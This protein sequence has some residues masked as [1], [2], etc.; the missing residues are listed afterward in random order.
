MFHLICENAIEQLML[1]LLFFNFTVY[2]YCVQ[3]VDQYFGGK[4]GN[5]LIC[6]VNDG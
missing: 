2:M 5:S 1:L 4:V 3:S 6:I